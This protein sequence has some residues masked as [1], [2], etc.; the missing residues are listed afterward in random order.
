MLGSNWLFIGTLIW[1]PQKTSL[2]HPQVKYVSVSVSEH[3]EEFFHRNSCKALES[4]AQDGGGVTITWRFL[5][6]DWL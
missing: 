4:A 1:T 3:E 2:L 6:K 5:A